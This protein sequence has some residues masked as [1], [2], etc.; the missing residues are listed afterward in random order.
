MDRFS[1][2]MFA[3]HE[4]KYPIHRHMLLNTNMATKTMH[5]TNVRCFVKFSIVL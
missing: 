2:C 4:K 1:A 3:Q 5:I